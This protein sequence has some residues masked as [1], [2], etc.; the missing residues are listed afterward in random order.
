[1]IVLGLEKC[2]Y[3][4]VARDIAMNHLD[5][6]NRVYQKTGTIWENYPADSISSG[7]ADHADMVGWSG[8]A[9]ILYLIQY[10]IGLHIPEGKDYLEWN[11]NREMLENGKVGCLQ[12]WFAGKT[13]D[14][15]A[16]KEDHTVK[17]SV[18]TN[19]TFKMQIQVEDHVLNVGIQGDT[20]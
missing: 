12:Y 15:E 11:L 5:V 19:D 18:R 13:A 10:A 2:G 3:P 1:M 7:D 17:I 20:E 16:V 8:I 6:I 14:F 4:K 9:P